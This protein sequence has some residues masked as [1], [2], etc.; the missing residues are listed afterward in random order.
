MKNDNIKNK[1]NKTLLII[2]IIT[3]I[4][5][6]TLGITYAAFS[7][8]QTGEDNHEVVLGDIYMHYGETNQLIMENVMPSSEYDT[9]NY[10]EFTISGKNTY[11][12]KDIY[13]EIVL[14]YGN[15]H[16]TRTERIKDELLRFTLKELNEDNTETTLVDNITLYDL[17]TGDRLYVETIDKNTLTEINKTYRLYAWIDEHTAICGGDESEVCD[18]YTNNT[19]NWN[20][21]FASIKVNVRGDF[22]EKDIR[23]LADTFRKVVNTKTETI[24]FGDDGTIYLSGLSEEGLVTSG[25]S[26]GL[27]EAV[28]YNYVWYSGKLWR[29]TA[30]N[31]DG[32]I[33]MITEDPVTTINWGADATYETSYVRQWLNQDFLQTLNNYENIIQTDYE[34]LDKFEEP[35]GL[36]TCSEYRVSYAK[37]NAYFSYSQAYLKNGTY[38]F[39]LEDIGASNF[40]VVYPNGS[41]MGYSSGTIIANVRPAINIVPTIEILSGN[42]TRTAPYI[43]K[44]E[45]GEIVNNTTLINT[46]Q[47]GEYVKIENDA[48]LDRVFRIVN[49]EIVDENLTTKLVTND[50][51][52]DTNDL[53]SD[54]NITEYL[55]KKFGLVTSWTDVDILDETY[56]KG[57][58]NN[59]WLKGLDPNYNEE[60]EES[61]ILTQGIYYLGYHSDDTSYKATVCK[62]VTTKETITDCIN[63]NN[64][65]DSTW[66]GY[67]G[68]LRVGE[69]FA[70][71]PSKYIS[72]TVI[73]M[74]SI[75]PYNDSDVRM[76]RYDDELISLEPSYNHAARPTIHLKSEIV[77]KS[78]SGTEQDPFIVG[79]PS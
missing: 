76:F 73:N 79:L 21:V 7:Y 28:D 75:T 71:Q 45:K 36:L 35:V 74:W 51:V 19:P 57:Y 23:F 54:S 66:K 20:D 30:I 49:T 52:K 31:P 40:R 9:T 56:W 61:S 11:T 62:K 53:D 1:K 63:N 18:Y 34:W 47:S 10:F 15:N 67:V 4:L 16:D 24:L 13:Y 44:E 48:D 5:L 25:E 38:W 43:L 69:M 46:R 22:Q 58:L 78:G 8:M 37:L 65:V 64:V 42:G 33:K 6:L 32:T 39:V 50:Y 3:T 70:R 55:I 14:S 59:T 68:L 29:I 27:T 77:I 17:A 60:I 2:G 41:D 72:S 12:E 26:L